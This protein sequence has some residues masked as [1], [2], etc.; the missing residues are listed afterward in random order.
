MSAGWD[1]ELDLLDLIG[2]G[3]LGTG[4]KK[5]WLVGGVEGNVREG[6][7]GERLGREEEGGTDDGARV[8][9]FCIEWGGM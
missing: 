1:E 3:R 4:V 5:G 2:G 7:S 6:G 8:R 9:T